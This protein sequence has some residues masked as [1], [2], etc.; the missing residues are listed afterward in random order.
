[1]TLEIA[2]AIV[3]SWTIIM[4][5]G[6]MFLPP[7]FWTLLSCIFVISLI[8]IVVIGWRR[9]KANER[10]GP[11]IRGSLWLAAGVLFWDVGCEGCYILSILI[12]PFWFLV[13]F[14][15]NVVW[16]PGWRIA[17]LR[18]SMPFLTFG[19]AMGNGRLQWKLSDANAERVIKA[20]DEFNNANGRYP[21]KLDELVPK[22]LPSVPPAK[23]CLLEKF[24]YFNSDGH[25]SL[26]WS[27]Y[28]FYRRFYNF[29]EKRWGNI[30]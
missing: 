7:Q 23:Y 27:R 5:L 22:Y 30:D 11:G 16:R 26:M 24:W 19:I 9:R 17:L 6:T 3:I 20:C 13:S 8:A 12:C 18:I 1:M 14:V 15:K 21:R 4:G 29:D 28:G 2:V 25:C 10:S